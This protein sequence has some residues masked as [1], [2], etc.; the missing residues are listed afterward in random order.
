MQ[1]EE[2]FSIL[3]RCGSKN[4]QKP[5]TSAMA[6]PLTAG[7]NRVVLDISSMDLSDAT[8]EVLKKRRE[9]EEL[10][11]KCEECKQ[12]FENLTQREKELAEELQRKREKM[13]GLLLSYEMSVKDRDTAQTLDKA[14]K[15]RKEVIEK[16]AE[17][18]RLKEEHAELKQRK[19]E[20]LHQVERHSV[21][22]DFMERVLKMTKFEDVEALTDHLE[23]LLHIRD[24]LFQKE[25]EAQEQ[26]DQLRKELLTLEDQHRLLLLQKNNELSQ[27]Q[28][29]L[30][31]TRSEAEIWERKWNH[32]Q[33]TAAKKTLLLGQIK[34]ATLNLYELTGG[35]VGG[36]EGVDMN[37]TEIQLDKIK[38][39]IQDHTD[40]LKLHQSPSQKQSNAKKRDKTKKRSPHSKKR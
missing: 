31:R 35:E 23:N 40:I 11:G 38:I 26:A 7:K 10:I 14:K 36:E 39:F 27:L 20:L 4:L 24:Q 37:D 25:S 22:Q 13:E 16:E 1:K 18:E 6:P 12:I 34:M 28:T 9:E 29:E 17:T 33:E 32:V 3:R 5:P 19:E 8:F 21:Y 15:E 2:D 30:E